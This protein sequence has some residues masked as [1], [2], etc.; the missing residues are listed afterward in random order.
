MHVHSFKEI[1]EHFDEENLGFPRDEILHIF[2]CPCGFTLIEKKRPIKS[3]F[4]QKKATIYTVIRK[5]DTDPAIT[6]QAYPNP[7]MK[8]RD[9]KV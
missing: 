9:S 6:L 1:T 4:R 5:N 7:T 8:T 3:N 2:E